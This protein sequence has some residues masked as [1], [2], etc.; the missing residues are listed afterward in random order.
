MNRIRSRGILFLLALASVT[1]VAASSLQAQNAAPQATAPAAA[2]QPAG[3][4]K[5]I[6]LEDIVAW[7]GLGASSLS[8]DGQWLSYRVSPLQGDSDVIVRNTATDKEY[9]VAVGEGGFGAA[10]F[11]DD[12]TYA[13]VATAPTRRA[14]TAAR[15]ARR[16]IQNGVTLI[17]LA[18]GTKTEI[19]KIRRF[20]FSNETHGW[21][22]LHRYGAD[23]PPGAG[24]P[25]AGGPPAV[26]P[27]G[28]A[29]A[30]SSRPRGT[31]LIVRELATGDELSL[32]NV[33]EWAFDKSGRWLAY[34]IDA[35]E[36]VG[37]GLQL[38]DMTSGAVRVL[39]SGKAWY[40]RPTWTDKGDGLAVLKGK[41]DRAYR[42]RLHSVVGFTGFSATAAP[43][44]VMLDPST[45][46]S[47]PEAMTISANRSPRWSEDLDTLIF[48]I[49][50]LRKSDR[51]ARPEP[52]DGAEAPSAPAAPATPP[53]DDNADEKPN[54]RIWH[55]KDAR[56]QSA[57][58][59]QETGDR[60]F[61]YL[62]VYNPATSKFTRIADDALRT[63]N[64]APKDKWAIGYD[65]REYERMGNLDGRAF[66]D[67]YTVNLA[68]GERKTAIRKNR[69]VFG[70]SPDGT[71]FLYYDNKHFHVYDMASGQTR[72]ITASVPAN[73]INIED[74]HN[75]VDPPRSP[76]GFSSD[77]KYVVLNDGWDMWQVPVAQGT[78][79]NLTVNG[80]KDG[81]RYR[82]R[83]VLDP[84]ERGIDLS[85]PLIVDVYG[86][87]TKKN[88]FGRIEPGKAGVKNLT[89]ED[90]IFGRLSKARKSDVIVY[91]K[92][93][94][95]D[96]PTL[97]V[98]N[99]AFGPAKKLTDVYP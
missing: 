43:K 26:T 65:V 83:Y 55:W 11:S 10:V 2:P 70:P 54:L 62:A 93:T 64:I 90:A 73:F 46:K 13:A 94:R 49:H 45:D 33:N 98:S 20:G 69:W 92:E 44:K 59:V 3:A 23:A 71:K 75:V 53:A 31:D 34:T 78:A 6:E 41:E 84:E 29:N 66:R 42:E 12:S 40:E 1:G 63:V 88:G 35:N 85:K 21:I 52:A 86:E 7:K 60:N 5:P 17:K 15:R 47:F 68:T 39:D 16:P 38:R 72:N 82:Q 81:I 97:Y 27:P 79:T 80:T 56:L 4:P 32:G 74:D 50:D 76:M 87:W 24:A 36:Q 95:G 89:W 8:G 30:P 48:G 18:D 91:S 96:S 61:S 58:Q 19:A 28:G 67:V 22:A 9:K 37:N 99:T 57:Q 25:P 14:A 77:S 51:P